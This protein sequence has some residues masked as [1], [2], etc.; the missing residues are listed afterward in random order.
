MLNN[1]NTWTQRGD[2]H[3]LG[4][5]VGGY[6]RDSMREGGGGITWGEMPGIGDGVMGATN[7]LVM[8]VSMQQSCVICTCTPESKIQ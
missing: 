3:M 6:R 4:S 2:H 7:H 1:E 8:N 5:I